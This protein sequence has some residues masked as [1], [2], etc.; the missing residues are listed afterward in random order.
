MLSFDVHSGRGFVNS[1]INKLPVELHL[2]GYNFCG[3]GTK[4]QKRLSRGDVGINPLDQACR[5]HDIAYF[6]HKSLVDRHKADELL[7]NR[8][9][10]RVKSKDASLGEKTAAWFVTNTI[11]SKRKLGMGVRRCG[12]ISFKR[13]IIRGI[14]RSLRK[15][16]GKNHSLGDEKSLR[17]NSLL[18]LKAARAIVKKAGGRKKIRIPRLIPIQK[19]KSGG[20]LPLLPLLGALGAL[21]SLAGGAS[22]VA[23]TVIDVKNARK[24]LEEDRRHNKAMEEIGKRG[25]GMYLRKFPKGGYGLYLR[26]VQKNLN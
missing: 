20:I 2:P 1:L 6:Q 13:D 9:W 18:A 22:A 15:S 4:L 8:A 24:K 25:S 23:K 17:K 3:P 14:T 19:G 21:G 7:E 12:A 10:E 5:E 16:V 26:K 11:K